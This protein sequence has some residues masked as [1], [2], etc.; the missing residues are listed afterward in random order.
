MLTFFSIFGQSFNKEVTI[1]TQYIPTGQLGTISNTKYLYKN[2]MGLVVVLD[3]LDRILIN[4]KKIKKVTSNAFN[5]MS[6]NFN[7][8][9]KILQKVTSKNKYVRCKD[10]LVAYNWIIDTLQIKVIKNYKCFYANVIINEI[11]YE[12]WFTPE[13]AAISPGGLGL[14]GLILESKDKYGQTKIIDINFNPIN[15]NIFS[16]TEGIM[17]SKEKY[18]GIKSKTI[19]AYEKAVIASDAEINKD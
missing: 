2:N 19:K 15:D 1:V 4:E 18:Y 7:L 13:I 16:L 6:I 5:M 9:T 12:A 3:S 17:L 11:K 10:T 14:S 8:N